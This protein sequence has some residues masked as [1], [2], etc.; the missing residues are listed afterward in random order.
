MSVCMLR[1]CF[2]GRLWPRDHNG[3]ADH[4]G[5]GDDHDIQDDHDHHDEGRWGSG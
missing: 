2:E 4:D 3:D 1:F 5:D